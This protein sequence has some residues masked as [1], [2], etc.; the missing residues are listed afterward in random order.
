MLLI[1]RAIAVS[2]L[3]VL[4]RDPMDDLSLTNLGD[5]DGDGVEDVLVLAPRYTHGLATGR[6]WLASGKDLS[7]IA[8]IVDLG[9]GIN[10]FAC[11]LPDLDHDGYRDMAIATSNGV[12]IY[13]CKTGAVLR[14]LQSIAAGTKAWAFSGSAACMGSPNDVSSCTLFTAWY[15]TGCGNDSRARPSGCLRGY[16]LPSFSQTCCVD[17]TCEEEW[18]GSSLCATS[19]NDVRRIWAAARDRLD[20]DNNQHRYVRDRISCFDEHLAPRFQVVKDRTNGHF[21]ERLL[22]AGDWNGDGIP[23]LLVCSPGEWGDAESPP[24]SVEVLSGVDGKVLSAFQGKGGEEFGVGACAIAD[25]D[26][27]GHED[28]V[29]CAPSAATNSGRAILYSGSSEKL[30]RYLPT[31][32]RERVVA[33]DCASVASKGATS[34]PLVMLLRRDVDSDKYLATEVDPASGEIMLE[35]PLFGSTK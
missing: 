11:A 2:L 17:G 18:L 15:T 7:L 26:G 13:S 14:R 22:D 16:S 3:A 32:K 20:I 6:A 4:V 30:L 1:A 10:A 31:K 27:D 33:L 24:G 28:I 19:R 8:D 5:I 9:G 25:V 29:V 35:N 12:T 21:G 34:K 23:D